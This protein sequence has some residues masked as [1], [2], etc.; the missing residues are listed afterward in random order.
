MADVTALQLIQR[1]LA[2]TGAG[3]RPQT[4][5]HVAAGDPTQA[6]S[7]IAVMAMADLATL[8]A[9]AA[10]GRNLA[11]TYDPGFWS[12]DD[13]FDHLERN[14]LFAEKRDLLR[15]HGMVLFNLHDHW[16]GRM[17]DGIAAGMAQALGWQAEAANPN[18][19]HL[20]PMTLLALAQELSAKLGDRTL[21]VVGD[22]KLP[23]A[24]IATSFGNAAQM[25]GIALLGGP[26]D[27]LVCGYTHEWEVVEYAQD[28]I[29]AGGKKGLVLL[30]Q[31]ASVS[32]GMRYCAGW[33]KE[34]IAEVPVEFFAAPE[35][36]WN[37]E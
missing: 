16:Q 14:A 30:G 36:Y 7:G 9:A 12:G 5:D 22:P 33:M 27:V 25:P 19:F 11:V 32:A 37:P 1:I 2:K 15:A 17:P 21:R 8:K 3:G 10:A 26:A 24:T 35:P 13:N 23:V 4:V 29:A 31:N 28:M 34:F 20:P 18:L 6:V